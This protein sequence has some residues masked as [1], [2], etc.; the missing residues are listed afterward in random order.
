[1]KKMLKIGT[2][3][4]PCFGVTKADG[5]MIYNGG[6]TWTMSNTQGQT[7]TVDDPTITA[8]AL[9]YINRPTITM[10]RM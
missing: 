5:T 9:E 10:G 6:D 7:Q 2:N 3:Y 1:M 4:G 8:G